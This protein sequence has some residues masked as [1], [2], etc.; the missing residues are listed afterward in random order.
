MANLTHS[1]IKVPTLLGEISGSYEKVNDRLTRY[2]IK[3]PANMSG[4]FCVSFSPHDVVTLNGETVNLS[5]GNIRLNP[6]NNDIE[7]RMNS[8]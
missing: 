3:L 4:S 2:S 5:F 7:I 1:T 6:G 8:F